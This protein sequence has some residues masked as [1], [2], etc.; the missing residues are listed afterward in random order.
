MPVARRVLGENDAITL[1][2]RLCYARALYKDNDTTLND[3]REA[4]STLEGMERTTRRVFGGAHPILAAIEISLRNAR[5]A[6]RARE[7]PPPSA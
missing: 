6:I 2:M 7:T 5:A 4:M 3:L 1:K